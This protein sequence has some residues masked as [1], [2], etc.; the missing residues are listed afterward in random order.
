MRETFDMKKEIQIF[1]N[2]LE[3]S[4]F[5]EYFMAYLLYCVVIYVLAKK[6]WGGGCCS[7]LNPF[8]NKPWF[9]H[10]D[11]CKTSLFKTLWEKK[12]CSKR[13]ISSFSTVFSILYK[14]FLPFL[15]NLSSANS[16]SLKKSKICLLGKG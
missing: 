8:P 2:V 3:E 6:V 14:N 16:F 9:L 11:V 15:S 12:N 13:A 7:L 10:V 5:I 4:I 1:C